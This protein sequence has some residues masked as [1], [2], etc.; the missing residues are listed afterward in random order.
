MAKQ[1]RIDVI[2]DN[3]EAKKRFDE[4]QVDL[5]KIKKLREEAFKGGNVTAFQSFDKEL[6]NVHK[7]LKQFETKANDVEKVLKNINKVSQ[8]DLQK[9]FSQARV[10]LQGTARDADNYTSKERNFIKL[11]DELDKVNG[12]IKS[13]GS[14]LQKAGA[15]FN[16]YFTMA[17]TAVAS[18]TAVVFSSR[19]AVEQFAEM[20]EAE[21]DVMKY[22]GLTKEAV[23]DLNNEFKNF[24]TRTSRIE[25]NKL[26]ADAGKLGVEGKNNLLDFAEAGNIIKIA[27]GEDL[28]ED[29][30]KNIGKLADMF[31]DSEKMGLKKAMLSTGSAINEVAQKSSAAEP[32]LVEFTN[33]MAGVGKQAGLTIPKILGYASVLDQNA[34]QVEMSAT[35]LS[36][37][38][39]KLFKDPAAFA[40]L[41]GLEVK[42]FTKLLK[43]DANEA[44]ILFLDTLGK[45][46]GMAQLAPIFDE[47]KLDGARASSVLS[48]LAGNIKQLKKEQETAN[49]AFNSGTSVINE[50]NIKNNTLQAR[51]E[52]NK[53]KFQENTY[54]LGEKLVPVMNLS[55][56]GVTKFLKIITI[57][58]DFY[59][60][61]AFAINSIVAVIG[62]YIVASKLQLLYTK[63]VKEA[64]LGQIIATKAKAV[65]EG[66]GIVVT[67]L[68]STAQMLLT[69][70]IKG[71]TQAWRVLSAVFKANPL[72]F[73][74]AAIFAI[75]ASLYAFS[76]SASTA[77]NR[78]TEWGKDNE[79][80]YNKMILLQT[81][82]SELGGTLRQIN[83]EYSNNENAQKLN[84]F[85]IAKNSDYVHINNTFK[86]TQI[87]LEN[88]RKI[89]VEEY[90]KVAIANNLLTITGNEQL[91]IYNTKLAANNFLIES[92]ITTEI[93]QSEIDALRIEKRKSEMFLL[94]DVSEFEKSVAKDNI[95]AINKQLIAKKSELDGYKKINNSIQKEAERQASLRRQREKE[96]A[97]E[98]AA[99]AAKATGSTG[100]NSKDKTKEWELS[101]DKEFLKRKLQLEKDYLEFGALTKEEVEDRILQ[102]EID[103]L[104]ARL[105]LN[106]DSK[107]VLA[108]IEADL[109]QK[110]IEQ[111]EKFA[112]K[113]VEI[114]KEQIENIQKENAK[115]L[116]NLKIKNNEEFASVKTLEDAKK[117]L[118]GTISDKELSEITTLYDAKKV[119]RE[120]YNKDEEKLMIGQATRLLEIFQNIAKDG[121]LNIGDKI[122]LLTPEQQKELEDK[123]AK[124]QE[125]IAELKASSGNNT[126]NDK[127]TNDKQLNNV[128]VDAFGFSQND[129]ET[130]FENLKKGKLHVE[131]LYMVANSLIDIW[132]SYSNII[133]KQEEKEL[134]GY[135]KSQDQKKIKLQK[136]LDQGR[137]SQ[138]FYNAEVQKLDAETENKK[139]KYA[140]D[141]AVRE[142][143][144]ALMSAMVNTFA[145]VAKALPNVAL[146]VIV[147]IAGAAQIA[148]ILATPVPEVPGAETG[149]SI[150][151]VIRSQDGQKYKAQYNPNKRG[152]VN[153]PTIITGENGAE[154]ILPRQAVENPT[155]APLLSIIEQARLN[156]SLSSINLPEVMRINGRERG[157]IITE[158]KHTKEVITKNTIQK[159][160]SLQ[161]SITKSLV[162]VVSKLNDRLNKPIVAETY[163]RGKRGFYEA[164]K[165]DETLQKNATL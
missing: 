21:A 63:L 44:L 16:N 30:I 124:L 34:Q 141:A 130:L 128:K 148:G 77:S 13:Q 116:T 3:A 145:A 161:M 10:E 68:F 83:Q 127:A 8:K 70:N 53:K 5:V 164:I 59:A 51:L 153:S 120:K 132:K 72:G 43:E 162:D 82:L 11:R 93:I 159:D 155:I 42:S 75:A 94:K 69:G 147:G 54:E 95:T 160:D 12:S 139:A 146:S 114:T 49:N 131:E 60:R 142:R 7:E 62:A 111:K 74:V 97:D 18:F 36:G 55:I 104:A 31:G 163:L 96:E 32:Y 89:A 28:G 40:K 109:I 61:H 81:K 87:E 165:E 135:V 98:R 50:Y 101:K 126:T 115:A 105:N 158:T 119:L 112:K 129:W 41:A 37:L 35:A 24:D 2:I 52:K 23:K 99:I 14:F 136:N 151:D 102:Y 19:K 79:D 117:L 39:M 156:G 137:I 1:A 25:L 154:Y 113:D 125:L 122:K 144:I 9:A 91:D 17:A 58:I 46:G 66:A 149:G 33:R 110:Q 48:V 150:M 64:T 22:A 4:L 88:K 47:M 92:R 138:E 134:N 27:L 106:K 121:S 133:A 140:H 76:K 29:A 15:K 85:Q 118:K 84:N 78:L 38:L 103:T 80:A 26:A 71:A 143:N 57:S 90:N 20:E 108:K 56:N 45:K 67:Q 100:D 6:K 157:G 73:A 152:F 65:A 123:I 107:E 86:T